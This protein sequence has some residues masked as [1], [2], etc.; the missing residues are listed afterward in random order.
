MTFTVSQVA[1]MGQ[2]SY[3]ILLSAIIRLLNFSM[4]IVKCCSVEVCPL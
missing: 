2:M 4:P 1:R 3:S